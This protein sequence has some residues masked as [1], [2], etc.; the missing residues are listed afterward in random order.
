MFDSDKGISITRQEY[1]TAYE[2]AKNNR[3]HLALFVRKEIW[4]LKADRNSLRDYLVSGAKR[5]PEHINN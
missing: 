3:I 5:A 4:D 2:L 1:R